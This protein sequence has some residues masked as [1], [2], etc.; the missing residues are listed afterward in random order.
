MVIIAVVKDQSQKD[1]LGKMFLKVTS[2]DKK[3]TNLHLFFFK[4]KGNVPLVTCGI[5]S[6]PSSCGELHPHVERVLGIHFVSPR[7]LAVCLTLCASPIN[8]A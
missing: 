3:M 2:L 8:P 5:A 6:V 1:S 4:I 7:P